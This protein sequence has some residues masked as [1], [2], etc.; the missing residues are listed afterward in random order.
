[1]PTEVGILI[2]IL[3]MR[4]LELRKIDLLQVTHLVSGE[5]RV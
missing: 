5:A 1:M 3:Q 4:K 2:P